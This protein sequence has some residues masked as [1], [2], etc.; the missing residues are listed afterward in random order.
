NTGPPDGVACACGKLRAAWLVADFSHRGFPIS[1][2]IRRRGDVWEV[3][4]T[5]YAPEALVAELGDRVTMD[6]VRR[7]TNDIEHVR[8]EAFEKAK[9][10]VTEIVRQ[11]AALTDA[12]VRDLCEL[13]FPFLAS[14]FLRL[15]R[16]DEA[17]ASEGEDL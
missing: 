1:I 4:T 14:R 8:A 9:N 5:I 13:R 2:F 6:V 7:Q 16:A 3:A 10:A 15:I 12:T 17:G 11:R